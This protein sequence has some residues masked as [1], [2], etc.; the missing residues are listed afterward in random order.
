MFWAD[1][2]NWPKLS[3][4]L[5]PAKQPTMV[6]VVTRGRSDDC[7]SIAIPGDTVYLQIA[8]SGPAYVFY[9]SM[10]GKNWQVLRVFRLQ[11]G[12]KPRIGFESQSPAGAGTEA[13]FSEILYV[14]KKIADIYDSKSEGL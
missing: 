12:L 5:S 9:S 10:D 7:N 11:E 4:E 1:D 3:F 6:T 13:V 8:K 14:K 2:H